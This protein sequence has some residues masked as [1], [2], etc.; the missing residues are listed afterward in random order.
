M[1]L[2][3]F[4]AG[5]TVTSGNFLRVTRNGLAHPASAGDKD[6]ATVAGVA[7]TNGDAQDLVLVNKDYVYDGL[8]GLTAGE[9]VYLSITSGQFYTNYTEFEVALSGSTLSGAYLTEVGTALGSDKLHVQIQLP[10][11]INR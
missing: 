1:T 7:I 10:V 8:P 11:F 2:I 4:R 3:S 5:E 6:A 9:K